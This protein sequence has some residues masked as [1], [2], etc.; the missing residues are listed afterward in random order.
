MV[1][2]HVHHSTLQCYFMWHLYSVL[3]DVD[4]KVFLFNKTHWINNYLVI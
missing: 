3:L 2:T 4:I 1:I